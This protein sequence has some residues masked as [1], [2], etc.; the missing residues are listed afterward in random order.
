M[1]TFGRQDFELLVAHSALTAALISALKIT[2]QGVFFESS[3]IAKWE[4]PELGWKPAHDMTG[5]NSPPS[6]GPALPFPFTAAQL[7]AFMLHG[8]GAHLAEGFHAEGNSPGDRKPTAELGDAQDTFAAVLAADAAYRAAERAIGA[9]DQSL[10]VSIHQVANMLAFARERAQQ[11]L[12]RGSGTATRTRPRREE[13]AKSSI[14]TLA[15]KHAEMGV[16]EEAASAT[17][18]KLMVRQLLAPAGAE[19]DDLSPP[20]IDPGWKPARP[21]KQHAYNMLVYERLMAAW[22]CGASAPDASD[23]LKFWAANPQTGIEGVTDDGFW[24][25]DGTAGRKYIEKASLR[26]AIRRQLVPRNGR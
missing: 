21:A 12:A 18:R 23:L 1:R 5:P 14:K 4:L 13:A 2:E 16:Q 26:K 15:G 10:L 22:R 25:V 20:A 9:P 11:R 17:W 8:W 24:H 6:A 7:A 3:V 19:S